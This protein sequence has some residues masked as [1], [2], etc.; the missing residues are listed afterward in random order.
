MTS[1]VKKLFLIVLLFGVLLATVS[2]VILR[3]N[4]SDI[5]V[6]LVPVPESQ[7]RKIDPAGFD[8][9]TGPRPISFPDDFGAHPDFLSEW[10]YYTG[11]LN[12]EDGRHFGYQLTI[13]RR[14]LVPP[15]ERQARQSKWATDQVYLAHFA[16]TDVQNNQ[17]QAFERYSRGS[18]GLAG[19]QSNPYQVWVEDWSVT[20]IGK[21]QVRLQA[22]QDGWSVDLILDDIKGPILQ[23]ERGFS[24][25]G[26]HP[27]NASYYI[28]QTRLETQGTVEMEGKSYQVAGISWMDHEFSTSALS[29]DQIGWDWFALQMEDGSELMV[30]TLRTA[31]GSVDPYSS[32]TVIY[33]D[34]STRH[35]SRKDFQVEV[36]G[37]WRSPVSKAN[38]PARWKI[39]VPSEELTLEI[40]PYISDQ[41]LNLSYKYWEGAVW[42]RGDRQGEPISG[43]GYIELT[44][45]AGSFAGEF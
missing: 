20:K 41:E 29:E 17:H 6:E 39:V 40:Q 38:Y 32:G 33:Q 16:V 10:W 3:N 43:D 24:Q 28:S 9:A 42:I 13:F 12:T 36:L 22:D 27:G 1:R 7:V 21:D 34:G 37:F 18:A 2:F 8:R 35:L 5:Q 45:Y 30:F 25:K 19:A 4:K 23:G 11:N 15:P 26:P 44:G 31:D 14:A